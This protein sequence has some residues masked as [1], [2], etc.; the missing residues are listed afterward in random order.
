MAD[1]ARRGVLRAAC[2]AGVPVLLVAGVV[3]AV[4]RGSDDDATPV[5]AGPVPTT[6]VPAPTTTTPATTLALPTSSAPVTATTVSPAGVPVQVKFVEGADVRL[7]NGKLVSPSGRDLTPLTQLLA[8][9]PGTAIERLFQRPEAD[10][11]AEK[12][13]AEARTG[14]PQPDLN[15]WYLL[16]VP[17]AGRAD[18]LITEL[19][20][21]AIVEDASRAPG[22]APPPAP[23]P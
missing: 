4:A 19:K 1:G 21:L 18:A 6:T 10:L 15:L 9:Y 23:G 2:L 13:A 5:A 7:R 3:A 14:R 11:A 8:R 17:G 16:R 12:A 22:P 20:R